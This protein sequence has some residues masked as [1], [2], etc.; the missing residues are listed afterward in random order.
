M[1]STSTRP[2]PRRARQ[3]LLTYNT[4][5]CKNYK[6]LIVIIHTHIIVVINLYINIVVLNIIF[7]IHY[8]LYVHCMMFLL[9]LPTDGALV[10]V[11]ITHAFP[12]PFES[13]DVNTVERCYG[14]I[15]FAPVVHKL[16]P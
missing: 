11:L 10:P 15:R 3:R 4:L 14:D 16:Y 9:Q 5:N 6:Q 8:L 13:P 12:K 1:H 2:E 7:L